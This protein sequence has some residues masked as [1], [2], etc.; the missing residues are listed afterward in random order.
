MAAEPAGQMPGIPGL[1]GLIEDFVADFERRRTELTEVQDKIRKSSS[2]ATSDKRMVTATVGPH[3]ELT[4]LKFNSHDYHDLSST[5][6]AAVIV[7]TVQKARDTAMD[8]MGEIV[9]PVLPPTIDFD[10]V[11]GGRLDLA[12]VLP[13]NPLETL[14]LARFLDRHKPDEDA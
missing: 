11:T 8:K 3:G 2:T 14:D 12:S 10:A 1:A 6:L 4:A 5:E 13:E 7:K 9:G